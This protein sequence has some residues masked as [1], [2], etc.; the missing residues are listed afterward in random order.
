MS[1]ENILV[2]ARTT[3]QQK[4]KSESVHVRKIYYVAI[5]LENA[6][7]ESESILRTVSVELHAIIF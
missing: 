7:Q 5:K 1:I 3:E 2:I 6:F 4:Q